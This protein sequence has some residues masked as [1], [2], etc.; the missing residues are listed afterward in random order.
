[1][2][3]KLARDQFAAD[4]AQKLGIADSVLREELRQAALKRR[5]HVEVRPA[6]LTEVERVLL[7]ALAITDPENEQSRRLVV[8]AISTQQAWF[9]HLG[10]F[11]SMRALAG[12]QSKDPMDAV[13][14]QAQ[15][16]LL[17]EALLGETRPPEEGEVLSAIKE[18]QERAI[19]NR[20]RELRQ[21]IAEAERRVDFAELAI[22]TQQKLEL[23]RALQKLHRN[24]DGI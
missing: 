6:A 23:D 10:S 24:R 2:P 8:D 12:R 18:I 17:A 16:A 13:E 9:Q 11:Q 20:L 14:D 22:L 1:M 19:V 3:E 5:D 4:A 15:K 7:R 21:L